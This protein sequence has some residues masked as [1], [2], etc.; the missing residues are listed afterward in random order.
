MS[1]GQLMLMRKVPNDGEEPPERIS[2][3]GPHRMG[4][5]ICSVGAFHIQF[6]NSDPQAG[7]FAE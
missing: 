2:D 1:I 7:L 4:N 5:S 6:N 3:Q